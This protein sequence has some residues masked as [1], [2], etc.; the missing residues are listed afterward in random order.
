MRFSYLW[1][2]EFVPRLPKPDKLAEL[3]ARHAFEVE[4]M[5]KRGRD[6]ILDVAVLSNRTPDAGGHIGFAREVAAITKQKGK[7][8]APKAL[9]PSGNKFLSV[10]VKPSEAAPRY[11]GALIRNIRIQPSPAWLRERLAALGVHAVNN[12][13][14]ITNYVMLES[15]HPLHAFDYDT[16]R[17]KRLNIRLSREGETIETLDGKMRV[18]P[19]G[20]IV[21]SDAAGIIDLCG[22][23]GGANSAVGPKT[24]T[25]FLQAAN[26]GSAHVHRAFS[27]LGLRTDAAGRYAAGLDPNAAGSALALAVELLREL[28]SGEV[29]GVIDIYPRRIA[30]AVI[31]LEPD[32]VNRLLGTDL[33]EKEMRSILER[34]SFHV[35]AAK[36]ILTV[37]VPTA[38]RDIARDVDLIEEIG[39]LSG[40]DAI[41]EAR[42]VGELITA[43]T[44]TRLAYSDRILSVFR[45]AGFDEVRTY[46]FIGEKETALLDADT[47]AALF[48]L[49][50]PQSRDAASLRPMIL[51]SLFGAAREAVKFASPVRFCEQSRVFRAP[52]AWRDT[53]QC[54]ENRLAFIHCDKEKHPAHSPIFYELKG[55]LSAIAEAL[56]LPE[57]WYDDVPASSG[58][59]TKGAARLLHSYQSA[60]MKIGDTTVGVFGTVHPDI[61][62]AFDL[63]PG[64]AAGELYLDAFETELESEK[65]Y[66]AIPKYPAILRDLAILV[67]KNVRM[68]DIEDVIQNTGGELLADVDLF[69]VF[70]GDDPPVGG[71]A[72]RKSLAFHLVFQS[73]ERTLMDRE[74]E[75]LM[76]KITKA[77]ETN[78]EW[79]VR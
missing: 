15:G 61:R 23:M 66:R 57:F 25:I 68:T 7:F 41:G 16:I 33:Q 75:A 13:V 28:A 55:S 79:E 44:D 43:V 11:H 18:L 62:R 46:S 21:A 19:S 31:P 24:K 53:P 69:D 67:P 65:E 40:Y 35:E 72:G 4:G 49:E 77:L 26:F 22:I 45:N 76:K 73:E 56:G 17:G 39:R 5:E 12:V 38:R 78:P 14:D 48:E 10:T 29:A 50:N 36:G 63:P 51:P 60:S 42:P 64:T 9:E 20:A 59:L 8:P 34:L 71:G 27:R 6:V 1:L 70:E 54:E 52:R 2:K 32:A 3:I 30:P 47:R 58:L 74:V 37:T